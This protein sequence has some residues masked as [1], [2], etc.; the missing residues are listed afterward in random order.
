MD[1]G[2][3]RK[4]TENGGDCENHQVNQHIYYRIS[5]VW[6]RVEGGI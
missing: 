3:Q 6:V 1:S 5:Q 2:R 4:D